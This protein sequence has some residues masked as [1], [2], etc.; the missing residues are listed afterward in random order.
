MDKV[1]FTSEEV[2]KMLDANPKLSFKRQEGKCT[3]KV[4]SALTGFGGYF[5][6]ADTSGNSGGNFD[7]GK[8]NYNDW[9]KV[10]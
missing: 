10:T 6:W 3:Q 5:S 4:Y 2:K 9:E 7:A 8:D 1:L